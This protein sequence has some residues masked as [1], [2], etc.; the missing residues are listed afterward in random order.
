MKSF[1]LTLLR[2]VGLYQELIKEVP[3]VPRYNYEEGDIVSINYMGG[4]VLGTISSS[5][6]FVIEVF[7]RE[8]VEYYMV[9]TEKEEVGKP[10]WL[11][12]L[13][14]KAPEVLA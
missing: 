12:S 2:K 4:G 8:I 10:A 6:Y 9:K 5:S 14:R 3:V 13:I 11:L 7:S 1:I